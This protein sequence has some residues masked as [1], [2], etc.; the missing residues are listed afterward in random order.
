MLEKDIEDMQIE[1]KELEKE[2]ELHQRENGHDQDD[3]FIKTTKG[4]VAETIT[5]FAKQNQLLEK[6][7]KQFK[8]VLEYFSEETG[9]GNPFTST[10]EFFGNFSTFLLSFSV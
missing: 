7:K 6:M 8:T 2:I 5:S 10:D 4:F 9:D 3:L 1:A